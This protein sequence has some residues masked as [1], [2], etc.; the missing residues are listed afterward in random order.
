MV[1]I[2]TSRFLLIIS[3]YRK[4]T[5]FYVKIFYPQIVN[6]LFCKLHLWRLHKLYKPPESLKILCFNRLEFMSTVQKKPKLLLTISHS[7]RVYFII[8]Q[9]ITPFKNRI[10]NF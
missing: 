7:I 1:L 2:F 6:N 8:F 5:L 4:N 10:N 9:M 3:C